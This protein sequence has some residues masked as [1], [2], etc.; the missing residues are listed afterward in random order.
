VP[1]FGRDPHQ[2]HWGRLGID[3]TAPLEWPAEFE[4]KKVPGSG[5]IRF[6]DYL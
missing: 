4:R 3:A 2:V 1:S 5:Q 6:E